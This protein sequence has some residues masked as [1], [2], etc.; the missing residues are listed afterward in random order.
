MSILDLKTVSKPQSNIEKSTLKIFNSLIVDDNTM[1][2]YNEIK[3]MKKIW[4]ENSKLF[5]VGLC[6]EGTIFN[7]KIN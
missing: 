5:N 2:T 4:M 7:K 6:P 1:I 3:K